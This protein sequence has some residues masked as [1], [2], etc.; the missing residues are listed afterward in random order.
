MTNRR[1]I[2]WPLN[3]GITTFWVLFFKSF[4]ICIL[5]DHDK[6]RCGEEEMKETLQSPS[7]PDMAS[8]SVYILTSIDYAQI[9]L[10]TD[11][12]AWAPLRWK[13]FFFVVFFFFQIYKTT[14]ATL[15]MFRI[16]NSDNMGEIW[17]RRFHFLTHSG[18]VLERDWW[19]CH[20]P[21]SL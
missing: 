10:R 21:F 20:T 7:P 1:A 4:F 18:K 12:P 2:T 9:F 6:L 8:R 11:D 13:F 16:A 3:I 5:F 15:K 14:T 17:H 19:F